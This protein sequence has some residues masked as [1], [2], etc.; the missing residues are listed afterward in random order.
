MVETIVNNL[1]AI[2][3]GTAALVSALAAFVS[4]WFN[5]NRLIET[6][7]QLNAVEHKV[8]GGITKLQEALADI[9]KTASAAAGNKKT[10]IVQHGQRAT[11]DKTE[12]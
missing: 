5:R 3:F 4:V 10:V 6:K 2:L 9:A 7:S 12:H 1:S 11:D 8:D